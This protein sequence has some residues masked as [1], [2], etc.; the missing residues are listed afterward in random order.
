M[1]ESRTCGSVRGARDETRVPTAPHQT[2][3][4]HVHWRPKLPP[5]LFRSFSLPV[6]TPLSLVWFPVSADPTAMSPV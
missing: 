1:R 5:Q 4:H 6:P 3:F 2:R